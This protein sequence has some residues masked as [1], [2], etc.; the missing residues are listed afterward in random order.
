MP[1]QT[2]TEGVPG[3]AR[4]A[5]DD[6]RKTLAR[7]WTACYF[8][9]ALLNPAKID[10]HLY[11]SPSPIRTPSRGDVRT[12]ERRPFLEENHLSKRPQS[13]RTGA[14]RIESSTVSFLQGAKAPRGIPGRSVLP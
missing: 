3:G 7:P 10:G 5:L 1:W 2:G 11:D 14:K 8:A 6:A 9:P 12:P 13:L 4:D